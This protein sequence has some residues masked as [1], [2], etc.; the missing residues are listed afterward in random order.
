MPTETLLSVSKDLAGRYVFRVTILMVL[1]A[2]SI[3]L[4]SA[5]LSGGDTLDDNFPNHPAILLKLLINF[6]LYFLEDKRL[7]SHRTAAVAWANIIL[8]FWLKLCFFVS[9][10]HL[11]ISHHLY[12]MSFILFEA[13]IIKD[14]LYLGIALHI[15]QVVLWYGLCFYFDIFK[16][17]TSN[18]FLVITVVCIELAPAIKKRLEG[19][20]LRTAFEQLTQMKESIE[21]IFS[22]IPD[23]VFVVGKDNKVKM[24]NLAASKLIEINPQLVEVTNV[25]L[26]LN[27]EET[28]HSSLRDKIAELINAD[29][30]EERSIGVSKIDDR[31]FDWKAKLV[32][33]R[34]DKAVT[35]VL[36]D[37]TLLIQLEKSKHESQMK[38]VMLR[39]VS[40]E[41]RTPANAFQNL[42]QKVLR[43][44]DLPE[45][46][47]KFL[48]LAS[49]SCKHFQS[50]I[51]D[52]LDYS[53]F[54]NGCFRLSKVKFDI[55]K[56]LTSS[57]K[58]FEYIIKSAGLESS[59]ELADSL[60]EFC[61]NDP[62]RLSQILM[63]LLSNAVKF[64]QRGSIRVS[65]APSDNLAILISVEDTGVGV[66]HE[67]QSNLFKLFGKLQENESLNP[68][69]CGL[70]LHI[71]NLLAIQMGGKTMDIESEAGRGSKFWFEICFADEAG[72]F[73]DC[74]GDI[75][76]DKA[77]V[78]DDVFK[79][80]EGQPPRVLIVDDY[81]FNRDILRELLLEL[82]VTSDEAKSGFEAI[83]RIVSRQESPYQLVFLDFEM[84]ELSGVETTARLFAMKAQGLL[85]DIPP[86]VAYTAYTSDDDRQACFAVGMSGFLAKPSDFTELK[87]TVAKYLSHQAESP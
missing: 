7:I 5:L 85:S 43:M 22:S 58:P 87:A 75:G 14:N 57:F 77:V 42:I 33:W 67:Q 23:P 12:R 20:Q 30:T 41:L 39:S 16:D 56:C 11:F 79:V 46:A 40:H 83:D 76:E 4:V 62:T 29:A 21:D 44:P 80:V 47:C 61:F 2:N 1:I 73:D 9:P 81:V 86:I 8:I 50:V 3:F 36:R 84:P 53:Q 6:S 82:N 38:N 19:N 70:G 74:L 27:S 26:Q 63:N 51:N 45:E 78:S 10:E 64:T 49:D 52:L 32:R 37:V 69:G 15:K 25:L 18:S 54:I 72:E 13:D 66:S 68:Q 35:L 31:L 17:I 55:R 48:G 65:A 60:P 59:L 24:A 71:S 34:E 28:Q